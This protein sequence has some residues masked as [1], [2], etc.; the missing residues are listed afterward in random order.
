[1]AVIVN[2]R[3]YKTNVDYKTG[4][5]SNLPELKS[6]TIYQNQSYTNTE[7]SAGMSITGTGSPENPL[8]LVKDKPVID[9]FNF[10]GTG[11]TNDRGFYSLSNAI[12][13]LLNNG[14]IGIATAIYNIIVNILSLTKYTYYVETT[15]PVLKQNSEWNVLQNKFKIGEYKV[16]VVVHD[17]ETNQVVVLQNTLG[18]DY[19]QGGFTKDAQVLT[20]HVIHLSLYVSFSNVLRA[21]VANMGSNTKKVHFCF[22]WAP[23]L[24]EIYL[25]PTEVT[26]YTTEFIESEIYRT[27]TFSVASATFTI[28]CN[29]VRQVNS[30]VAETGVFTIQGKVAVLSGNITN[31]DYTLTAQTRT[32]TLTGIRIKDVA[33]IEETVFAVTGI[34]VTFSRNTHKA[35]TIAE[36]SAT[37]ASIDEN[38][39]LTIHKTDGPIVIEDHTTYTDIIENIIYYDL[40]Y[41]AFYTYVNN[42]WFTVYLG[43]SA[44][45]T[46]NQTTGNS[47]NGIVHTHY[48]DI[49]V[50]KSVVISPTCKAIELENDETAPARNSFYGTRHVYGA[51]SW[52][53]FQ[54]GTSTEVEQVNHALAVGNLIGLIGGTWQKTI[55]TSL[56]NACTV[57][58][59]YELIHSPFAPTEHYFCYCTYGRINNAVWDVPDF[60]IGK[61]YYLSNT[62]AGAVMPEPETW[63]EGDIVQY[64]GTGTKDGL[65]VNIEPA[66]VYHETA[67]VEITIIENRTELTVIE[68]N[69]VY[70]ETITQTFIS[71]INNEWVTI[72]D[73]TPGADGRGIVSIE[74]TSTVGKVKTYTITYTDETTST[75]DVTDGKDGIDGEDGV[76]PHIGENGNWWIG[77]T[78]TGIA[79]TGEDGRAVEMS[80]QS[81][82]VCWRLV[83]DA[84]WIQLYEIPDGGANVTAGNGM[85]FEDNTPVTLGTPSEVNSTTINEVT[86]HSHTHKLG[87]ID[88]S[89]VSK[90]SGYGAL[91]NWY[92]AV[93]SRKISSSDNYSIPTN[94]DFD[95][96][97]EYCGGESLAGGKL[98]EKGNSRWLD[99]M[100]EP[101][102]DF[103]FKGVGGGFRETSMGIAEFVNLRTSGYI[104]SSTPQPEEFPNTGYTLWMY[105]SSSEASYAYGII[106]HTIGCS[107]RFVRPA[108]TEELLLPDGTYCTP[109][110]GN[111]GKQYKTV[112]IGIQVWLAENLNETKFRDG[113]WIS[114]YDEGIYIPI[115]N[116]DWISRG[117]AGESLMCYYDDNELLGSGEIPLSDLLISEH[118][119]L[120]GLDGGDPDNNY[121]GH[122]TQL[123]LQLIQSFFTLPTYGDNAEAIADGLQAGNLY[124]TATGQLMIVY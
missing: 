120:K 116:E 3:R 97:I 87:N 20:D 112:K 18:F 83:G 72:N 5:N 52:L 11:S 31:I 77:E 9:F 34:D 74:L 73:G 56:E 36:E 23:K 47:D 62:V 64:I 95:I 119:K 24:G 32:Y 19:T 113:S 102:D 21:V 57:G 110:I 114:G 80:V 40:T 26:T 45:G 28:V 61:K 106:H 35:V 109:Y 44:P 15:A 96:L 55:A 70:Y 38:Q 33:R 58:F 51:R 53:K 101:T 60:E 25:L 29:K 14:D 71:Y 66:Y 92:A 46:S 17:L 7:V 1:M 59:V 98:K 78:D 76:T 121:Y 90:A 115:S 37:F 12:R 108:T 105:Y 16:T 22:E 79:A 89:S 67:P 8:V 10:Y 27:F 82:F 100:P 91:Y 4:T 42:Q 117:T 41:Q 103:A 93:D 39:V 81:N 49:L 75:F 69:I 124:K 118:N 68:Q 30:C 54:Y 88:I 104:W 85:D 86:E 48:I 123:E 2:T 94:S 65:E 43:Y 6:A 84:N 13:I 63:Q 111:N 107:I 122:L 50:Q 99:Q